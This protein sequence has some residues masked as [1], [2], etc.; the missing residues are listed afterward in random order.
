MHRFLLEATGRDSIS[1]I[2]YFLL[3]PRTGAVMMEG[4]VDPR[5]LVQ[6]IDGM[7]IPGTGPRNSFD[8][9]LYGVR[10]VVER[11][12]ERVALEP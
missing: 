2:E 5:T 4:K 3:R 8:E 1:R 10:E 7:R 6:T 12:R 11:V 9:L